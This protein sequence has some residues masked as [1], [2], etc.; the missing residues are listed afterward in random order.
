MGWT[1]I[2]ILVLALAGF[3]SW[4][5]ALAAGSAATLDWIDARFPRETG[6]ELVAQ[7]KYGPTDAQRAEIWVP[8]GAAPAGGARG[9]H[10]KP[11]AGSPTR[12]TAPRRPEHA[13]E[14]LRSPHRPSIPC[15]YQ[16]QCAAMPYTPTLGPAW[17]W[18]LGLQ[19]AL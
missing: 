19:H 8:E 4:R 6:I 16:W 5:W 17:G 10:A 14:L 7:G 3:A 13:S 1:L 12:H 11:L 2:A 18:A 9:R 15:P